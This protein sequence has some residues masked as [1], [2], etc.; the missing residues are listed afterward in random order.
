MPRLP[1]NYQPAP[2]A[3][4]AAFYERGI[5]SPIVIWTQHLLGD[6]GGN[7]FAA[8]HI[9]YDRACPSCDTLPDLGQFLFPGLVEVL[10]PE[11]PR[12]VRDA[13]KMGVAV[14]F[15]GQR[16]QIQSLIGAAAYWVGRPEHELVLSRPMDR[17]L[18]E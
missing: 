18:R 6:V 13:M 8:I 7:A 3:G 14:E 5:P 10:L 11:R 4:P 9:D 15:F 16:H 2:L 12:E 17:I 1:E